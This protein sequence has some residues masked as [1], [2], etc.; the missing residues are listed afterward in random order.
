MSSFVFLRIPVNPSIW[1]Y[2]VF[3]ELLFQSVKKR[4][5]MKKRG[6][7]RRRAGRARDLADREVAL[8]AS[9]PAG[10]ADRER[11]GCRIR[12]REPLSSLL[13]NL[14]WTANKRFEISKFKFKF[15][16]ARTYELIRARSR[17]YQSQILQVN[18]RWNALAE[19][20]TMHLNRI[21]E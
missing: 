5:S 20:Y 17:L 8:R 1:M 12:A 16:R 15:P 4:P 18:T 2:L 6:R 19:I 3:S 11:N 9:G 10:P 7:R 14:S 21:P 13:P